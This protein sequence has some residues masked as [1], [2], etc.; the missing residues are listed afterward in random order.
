MNAKPSPRILM[1]ADC[2]GGVWRYA[3]ELVRGL[4]DCEMHL[5]VLGGRLS[6]AQRREA[7]CCGARR[8]VES[9]LK[10]EW[11]DDPWE[12]V[13]RSAELLREIARE[14]APDVI[15]LNG[16]ALAA[17]PWA[18]PVLVVAHSCV[19]SWWRAV[20]RE[21]PPARLGI[22]RDRVAAGLRAADAIV[23]PT[24]A[25][26]AVLHEHYGA[27]LSGRVIPNG[28][29][30]G[31]SPR[32]S[33]LP[34]V[35]SAGRLWDEAKNIALLEAIAPRT[36]WAIRVAGAAERPLRGVTALGALAPE[37]MR[38]EMSRAAIY[39]APAW[40][41]PFGL[42]V[43][44]AAL[45]GCALVLADIPTFREL[46]EGAAWFADP[47]SPPQWRAALD[48]L[49][50]DAEAR[51]ELAARARLRALRL[52]RDHMAARYRDLYSELLEKSLPAAA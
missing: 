32:A 50:T 3:M 48:A 33:K 21:A 18:A 24:A 25:M 23:A 11:M 8:V 46:W 40:Y 12:D 51:E 39:A 22:Y 45:S 4:P 26:L 15:H 10:L 41:E 44:E 14:C 28:L 38:E 13:R 16:Y 35:L 2:V 5:V 17:E 7:E 43:L 29:D 52:S 30:A 47:A 1:T 20:K 9:G 37:A 49:A 19:L 42:A 34:R 36:R 27:T 6:P 31:E